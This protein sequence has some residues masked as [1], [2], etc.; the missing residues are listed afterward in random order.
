M[1]NH[2]SYV[3]QSHI[4]GFLSQVISTCGLLKWQVHCFIHS[5]LVLIYFAYSHNIIDRYMRRKLGNKT[6]SYSLYQAIGYIQKSFNF[7]RNSY[8]HKIFCNKLYFYEN[9]VSFLTRDLY[10]I[11]VKHTNHYFL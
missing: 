6:L 2:R 1:Y 5:R 11:I 4:S 10:F 3:L 9:L 7:F 8:Y